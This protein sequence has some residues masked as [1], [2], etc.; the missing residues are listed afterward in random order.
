MTAVTLGAALVPAALRA[1][2][3][4]D[5]NSKIDCSAEAGALDGRGDVVAYR[6]AI[7]Q[8]QSCPS[9]VGAIVAAWRELPT[10][11]INLELLGSI[12]GYFR[13]QRVLDAATGVALA[14]KRRRAERLAAFRTLVRYCR[15]DNVLHYRN[16]NAPHLLG[17]QYVMFGTEAREGPIAMPGD[18]PLAASACRSVRATFEAI[19]ESGGDPVVKAIASRLAAR[20]Q[21][22]T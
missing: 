22:S 3:A 6:R 13:D 11:S 2:A 5:T 9:A 18:V 17:S 8:I 20:L 21:R 7:V 1:Q 14:S 12:S 15:S 10:D 16:L 19:G 4:A